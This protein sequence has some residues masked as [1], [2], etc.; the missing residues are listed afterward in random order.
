MLADSFTRPISYFSIPALMHH[1]TKVGY[2]LVY[3]RASIQINY[4]P[5]RQTYCFSTTQIQLGIKRLAA[6]IAS[7]LSLSCNN[8]LPLQYIAMQFRRVSIKAFRGIQDLEFYDLGRINLLVGQ[9]NCGKTSVLEA[10]HVLGNCSPNNHF[11]FSNRI[12]Y[13]KN[14]NSSID[15]YFPAELTDKKVFISCYSL[16]PDAINIDSFNFS[17][18]HIQRNKAVSELKFIDYFNHSVRPKSE[19]NFNTLQ[20]IEHYYNGQIAEILKFGDPNFDNPH[21]LHRRQLNL[22]PIETCRSNIQMMDLND[23]YEYIYKGVNDAIFDGSKK[24]IVETLS[25]LDEEITEIDIANEQVLVY[26]HKLPGTKRYAVVPLEYFGG[27]TVRMLSLLIK[28]AECENGMLMIDEID[29]AMHYTHLKL[30]W[31]TLIK[32]AEDF[33]VQVF[34]TTH[35]DECVKALAEI[36]R[37]RNDGDYDKIEM[38]SIRMYHIHKYPD[39]QFTK[40]FKYEAHHIAS[41]CES[42]FIEYR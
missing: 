6:L 13:K 41:L 4:S 42:P 2:W 19:D 23:N 12:N 25:R 8:H 27:A 20:T 34:V 30:I 33:N 15:S 18:L 40:A 14:N 10:M 9:N 7:L 11:Y 31:E 26:K 17:A 22:S 39:K 38:E 29:T 3:R 16:L 24:A 28:L 36:L 37:E 5:F 21:K 32:G 35:S 1:S